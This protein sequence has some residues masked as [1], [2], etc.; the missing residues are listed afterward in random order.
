[1]TQL[2]QAQQQLVELAREFTKQ[3]LFPLEQ[4]VTENGELSFDQARVVTGLGKEA[5]LFATNIGNEYGGVGLSVFENVLVQE[6]LG[7]AKDVLVRRATGN[8]Y[9]CLALGTPIQQESY[10]LPAVRGERW[11]SLAV[12]E[13]EAGS[14]VIAIETSAKKTDDG[15]LLN[16][17][18]MYI[19]DAEY[20]DYFIVAAK[21]AP[22]LGANGIS[23]FLVDKNAPGFSLGQRFNMMGFIGTSHNELI[24]DNIKLSDDALL[25]DLNKGF[26]LLCN[27]L[28]KARLAKVAARGLGKCVRLLDLM[29]EHAK[30][31]HQ[32]EQPLVSNGTIQNMLADSTMEIRAA[33]ALLWE[34]A[35]SMDNGLA[36]REEISMLKVLVTELLGKVADHAVQIFGAAG[37]HDGHLIESCYRDA[38]LFRIIDGTSEVHRNILAKSLVKKGALAVVDI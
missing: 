32:F 16:G 21:T 8:I 31:R 19:S 28:G 2:T 6:Q 10:L 1:M 13:P 15:W 30:T 9:E 35:R 24:F 36:C 25:G 34:T 27:T 18:K 12:S 22:G 5:G 7:H 33:R 14:D 23:L 20:S 38:R 17:R 26:Q 37:C 29:T 3:H 11:C 4:L